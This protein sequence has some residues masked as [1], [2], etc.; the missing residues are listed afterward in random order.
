MGW[1]GCPNSEPELEEAEYCSSSQP[2]D[3]S[4]LPERSIEVGVLDGSSFAPYVDDQQVETVLGFQGTTMFTPYVELP[5]L[6]SDGDEG[7]WWI[8]IEYF[9]EVDD[10]VEAGGSRGGYVFERVD[11]VMRAGPFFEPADGFYGQTMRMR[12]TVVGDD[13]VAVDEVRIAFPG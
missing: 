1:L 4:N 11:D 5:A 10:Y 3:T 8:Q 12:V 13:F 7:C 2:G 9:N 6:D